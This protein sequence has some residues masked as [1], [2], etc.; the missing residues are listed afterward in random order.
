MASEESYNKYQVCWKCLGFSL[1]KREGA[2]ISET[3]NN[4][5]RFIEDERRGVYVET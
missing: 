3:V 2:S 1:M 4:L 5:T